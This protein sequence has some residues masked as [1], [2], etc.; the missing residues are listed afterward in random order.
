MQTRETEDGFDQKSLDD[1]H[2]SAMELVTSGSMVAAAGL[3]TKN[4]AMLVAAFTNM[5]LSYDR[6][7]KR[8]LQ[9]KLPTPWQEAQT[10]KAKLN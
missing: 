8:A 10:E 6:I 7:N 5:V 3:A 9:G 2:K 1:I 4:A